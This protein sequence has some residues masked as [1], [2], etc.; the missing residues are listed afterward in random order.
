MATTDASNDGYD[1]KQLKT[2]LVHT[3]ESTTRGYIR[4]RKAETSEVTMRLPSRAAKV[5]VD[6]DD[7]AASA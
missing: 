3:E 5:S 2:A 7:E 4:R 6:D 1:D